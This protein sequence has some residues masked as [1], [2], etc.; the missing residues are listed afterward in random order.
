M[1]LKSRLFADDAALEACLVRDNAHITRG[2]KGEH[3]AKIQAV[4]T[5]LDGLSIDEGELNAKLYGPSTAAAVLAY[6]KRRKIINRAYESTEDDIVGKMTIKSLDDELVA[7][8]VDHQA[9]GRGTGECT[10]ESGTMFDV[11]TI[12]VMQALNRPKRTAA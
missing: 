2:A 7:K 1:A 3:V 8:Q 4:V 6:K 12:A 9:P 11:R 10:V 5:F